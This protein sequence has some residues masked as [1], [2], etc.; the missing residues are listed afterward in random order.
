MDNTPVD[1][2]DTLENSHNYALLLRCNKES[3]Y[4]DKEGEVYHYS[5]HVPN[6][7]KIKTGVKVLF[8]RKTPEGVVVYGQAVIGEVREEPPPSEIAPEKRAS[9]YFI[10]ELD[11]FISFEIKRGLTQQ[12][13][14]ML[15]HNDLFKYNVQH[16][17]RPIS[18]ELFNYL[19]SSSLR[20]VKTV[21][22]LVDTIRAFGSEPLES[23]NKVPLGQYFVYDTV[24]GWI[25]PCKFAGIH[26][27]TV[28]L[29]GQ[30]FNKGAKGSVF[31]SHET[32][33]RIQRLCGLPVT[34]GSAVDALKSYFAEREI[35]FSHKLPVVYSVGPDPE[36]PPLIKRFE[37]E[38]LLL[39]KRQK[40]DDNSLQEPLMLLAA[41]LSTCE[42]IPLTYENLSQRYSEM[43]RYCNN[44]LNPYWP[45]GSLRA[46]SGRNEE[47]FWLIINDAGAMITEDIIS[48]EAPRGTHIE[49]TGRR[50][51]CLRDARVAA[52]IIET[53]L[54]LFNDDHRE[55]LKRF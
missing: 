3:S 43:A 48:P 49:W 18:L 26:G 9:Q 22:E 30:L 50:D 2:T 1:Q 34:E 20:L 27:M 25:A 13:R 21:E 16:A 54:T 42:G 7:K 11:D 24:S 12:E 45:C 5:S 10:A 51:E 17:V 31:E 35:A 52:P 44:E 32:Q 4:A 36:Q 29:Y 39:R 53:V 6:N 41:V 38:I 47:A 15:E 8:D 55:L 33:K 14:M 40:N 28:D 37:G 46:P 23:Q 19:T